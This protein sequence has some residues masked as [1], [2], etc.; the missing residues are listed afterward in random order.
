MSRD[1]SLGKIRSDTSQLLDEAVPL[2]KAK[3]LEMNNIYN[4]VDK[5][6]AFVKM[7]G[8]HIS[9]LEEQVLQA[10]KAH[11]IFPC[12]VQKLFGSAAVPSSKKIDVIQGVPKRDEKYMNQ[13]E[14][15]NDKNAVLKLAKND[16]MLSVPTTVGMSNVGLDMSLV[17]AS[18]EP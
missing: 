4:K 16:S 11:A 15:E 5:L 14:M 1:C 6:E 18:N 17:L 10:E 8:H 9:F 7:A 13:K 3:V 12:T 2:I